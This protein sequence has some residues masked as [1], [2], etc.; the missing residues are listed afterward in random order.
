M[1][2]ALELRQVRRHLRR[3]WLGPSVPAVD[4]A[5]LRVAPGERVALI[6]PSGAGKSTLVRCGLGLDR[7]DGGQ[8]LLFGEEPTR[9]RAARRRAQL[10]LQDGRAMLHPRLPIGLLLEE[11]AAL[12][13]PEAD[14]VRVAAEALHAVGL[15]DRGLHRPRELSGGE[16][17]R[18]GLA[19]VL[20]AR[21]ELLVADEPT[22]GLDAELRRRMAALLFESCG[23]TT[24]LL[25][26]THDLESVGPHCDRALV[27]ERGRIVDELDRE[28]IAA[29]VRP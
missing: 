15:S 18:A 2:A 9:S 12:H 24:A 29:R 8:V 26:V 22:A 23:P 25:V 11:S 21:P 27:M 6:G 5:T 28:R 13:R 10:L 4:G 16:R 3:G 14:P 17:R 1:S 20:I 19:R 7:V